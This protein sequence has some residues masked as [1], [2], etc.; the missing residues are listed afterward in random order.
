MVHWYSFSG[1]VVFPQKVLL[2]AFKEQ[3]AIAQ[4]KH[5]N[6]FFNASTLDYQPYF[7]VVSHI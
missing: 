7:Q 3:S 5:K 2:H 6:K 1:T 4:Y